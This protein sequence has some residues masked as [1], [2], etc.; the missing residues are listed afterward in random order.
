MLWLTE[1]NPKFKK[2]GVHTGKHGDSTQ[3]GI[4][5]KPN[6]EWPG[7]NPGLLPHWDLGPDLVFSGTANFA[8]QLSVPVALSISG[9]AAGWGEAGC[10]SLHI[11]VL[12]GKKT[13]MMDVYCSQGNFILFF[14]AQA[15]EMILNISAYYNEI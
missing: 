10:S 4:W 7:W 9:L 13:I 6:G 12:Y 2:R 11:D 15:N 3:T 8:W 14:L 1:P 5:Q